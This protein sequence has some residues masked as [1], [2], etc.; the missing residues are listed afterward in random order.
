MLKIFRQI[1]QRM[2]TNNKFANYILY[3]IG[4]VILVIIGILIALGINQYAKKQSDRDLRNL[5]LVQLN[6]EVDRNIDQL[7]Q[8]D[9]EIS[10]VIKN[11]DTL[12]QLLANKEFN[13]PKVVEKTYSLYQSYTFQPVM[14]TYENLKSSGDLKLFDDLKLR[15]SISK[16]YQTFDKIKSAEEIDEKIMYIYFGDYLLPNVNFADLSKSSKGYAKSIYFQ[17]LAI[18]RYVT[19]N[20]IKINYENSIQ[21]LKE[22]KEIFSKLEKH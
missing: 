20:Q 7:I 4:E 13:N 19:L 5:Y 14:I 16:A 11:N 22:L 6:D 15:N 9:T 2:L 10:T 21:A 1:R 3:A 8:I 18:S 17:N 12:R